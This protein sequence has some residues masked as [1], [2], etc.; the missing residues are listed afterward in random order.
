MVKFIIL[1]ADEIEDGYM[2][3]YNA[4]LHYLMN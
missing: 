4:F 3:E 2:A 1:Q